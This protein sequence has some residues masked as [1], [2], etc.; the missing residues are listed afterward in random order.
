ME[1][2][3][4]GDVLKCKNP[5]CSETFATHKRTG[6]WKECCSRKC[7]NRTRRIRQK[8]ERARLR[9]S[10]V[11]FVYYI[12]EEHYVG[13]TQ[14]VEKRMKN[15]QKRGKYIDNYEVL[16]CFERRVDAHLFETMFHV[17]GYHG[18]QTIE[19]YEY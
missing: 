16:G 18:F 7:K 3:N 4:K 1:K 10:G 11:T 13:M 2:H 14:N 5:E 8:E 12:P 19:T 9:E 6:R 15:H 17:R